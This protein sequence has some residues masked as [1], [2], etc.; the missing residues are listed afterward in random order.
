[1]TWGRRKSHTPTAR[2]PVQ[3]SFPTG[4]ERES[5]GQNCPGH[6]LRHHFK[7]FMEP[8]GSHTL[9]LLTEQRANQGSGFD[10]EYFLFPV[11]KYMD[12]TGPDVADAH[13]ARQVKSMKI[14]KQQ[15][16]VGTMAN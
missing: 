11:A 3:C 14:K 5:G 15:G 2:L 1:M 7:D 6:F 10:S 4:G 9:C 16:M 13:E 12:D 8:H